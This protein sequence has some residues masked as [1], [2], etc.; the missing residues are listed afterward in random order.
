M[1]VSFSIFMQLFQYSY[2]GDCE[3]RDSLL[4]LQAIYSYIGLA[5]LQVSI[6]GYSYV[7]ISRL[8]MYS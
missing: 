2:V 7:Y 4:Y 3:D 8:L 6:M 1:A 5:S